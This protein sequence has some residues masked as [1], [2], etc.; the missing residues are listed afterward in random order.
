MKMVPSFQEHEVDKFFHHFENL[1]WP[2]GVRTTL[3]QSVLIGKAR[4][5]YSAL[6]VEHSTDYGTDLMQRRTCEWCARESNPFCTRISS[7]L[8]RKPCSKETLAPGT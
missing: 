2:S 4:E 8:H 5:V 3:L 6:S 7:I 1:H